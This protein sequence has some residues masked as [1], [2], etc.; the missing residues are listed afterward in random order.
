MAVYVKNNNDFEQGETIV[1]ECPHCGAQA[2]IVPVATPRFAALS[3]ARPRHAGLAFRC[4]ACNEPRFLRAAIR[5]FSDEVIVLSSNL[6]EIE[7]GKEPFQYSY[8]PQEVARLL[9]EAFACYTAD[10]YLSFAI[11]CRRTF[12]AAALAGAEGK[13]PKLVNLFRD[14]AHLS[15]VDRDTEQT[16]EAVLFGSG[17]EP[18]IDAV[19][20]AV[21]I[22]IVKDM[23]QQR[24]VRTAKLKRAIEMRRFFAGE[25]TQIVTPIATRTPRATSG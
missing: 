7:R 23:F 15:E 21:L 11:L 3:E 10:L 1:R 9:R 2:P 19:Q 22:E 14:A 13:Q 6:V 8:L 25:T 17:K 4:T 20:A 18:E 24:Y 5:S 12:E 16:L